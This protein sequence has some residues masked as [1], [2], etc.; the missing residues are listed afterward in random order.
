MGQL[1]ARLIMSEGTRLTHKI[2]P[3]CGT[4]AHPNAALCSACGASL[5]SVPQAAE[6]DEAPRKSYNGLEYDHHYG[7]TDLFETNLRW[8]GG[9]YILG[10]MLVLLVLA[11]ISGVFLAG[12]RLYT[13]MSPLTPTPAT[14]AIPAEA[15]PV[16]ST[17]TPRPT[18]MLN[19]VT[20]APTLTDTPAPTETPGPCMQQVQPGDSL[21]AI[22]G[23]CGHRNLAVI[24]LV[25]EI[26]NLGAP[27][28]IQSG[29]TLEI[30]WPTVMPDPNTQPGNDDT[31]EDGEVIPEG[32]AGVSQTIAE[33]NINP[34]SGL[35]APATATLLPGVT[36]HIV[37]RGE[38]IIVVA[39]LYGANIKILSELNPEITF[40]QCDFGLDTGGEQCVVSI[41]EGQRI[42][43][44]APTPTPTLSPTPSG[45][46][47]PTPT[48]TPTFN[49]PSALS[50]GDL[51]LFRRNDIITLRW[52]ATGSLGA[53]QVYRVQVEDMT[54]GVQYE[55]DT[56]D[57]FFIVPKDWQGKTSRRHEYRWMVSVIDLERPDSPYFTT[58]VRTFTW[59]AL[60]ENNS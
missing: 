2:C 30:P 3:I 37:T 34:L 40:S 48:A 46:E 18:L 7:E 19:T 49:A 1:F 8:R 4:P 56:A 52:V 58:E 13:M 29:Q 22:V 47:T 43:V 45:S 35:P 50:P 28:L 60:T 17:N 20:P 14:T 38:N 51:M 33:A 32:E 55:A 25:V 39:Y 6:G 36:W 9:T 16:L 53:G 42:R 44:P 27:E 10:G 31:S 21:I 26:N 12:T 15:A 54:S 5:Q 24:D 59:E 57:L 11:C 23:R 41:Y